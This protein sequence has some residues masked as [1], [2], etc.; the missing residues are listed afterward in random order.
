MSSLVTA[1]V[2]LVLLVRLAWERWL[3]ERNLAFGAVTPNPLVG[4][5]GG[6]PLTPELMA[7]AVAYQRART[8]FGHVAEVL[9][10]LGLA[11]LLFSGVLPAAWRW[12]TGQGLD[13]VAASA[14][15]AAGALLLMA[16]VRIPLDWHETFRLE[17][18]FGF[19][20]STPALFWRDSLKRLLLT[21]VLGV[22][23]FTALTVLAGY[24]GPWWWLMAA[25]MAVAFQ[26]L[27]TLLY[28]L[29]ILPWF[30]HCAPLE[31]DLLMSLKEMAHDCRFPTNGFWVLNSSRRSRHSN[32]FVAGVGQARRIVLQDTLLQLLEKAEI[33]A[34]VAHEIG[35]CRNGH[36]SKLA[37][38]V[39]L[40][41]TAGFF[42]ASRLL[43]Y[44]P[45]LEGFGFVAGETAP[46][47]LTLVL[48][49]G[50]LL[51]WLTPLLH[52]VQRHFEHDADRVAL[53]ATYS[54]QPLIS[55]LAKISANSLQILEPHPWY[56]LY[57]HSHPTLAQRLEALKRI[58]RHL[59]GR[60]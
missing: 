49:A 50:P 33:K 57:H 3:A 6:T 28:P 42:A 22:P 47:L 10:T 27:A 2:A 4:V 21:L 1:V 15:L 12:L 41:L 39:A 37:L 34:V 29:L 51:F 48:A 43:A 23:L 54:P 58:Q 53:G 14:T 35:H 52:A 17:A 5:Y 24:G 25:G 26:L 55:A 38:L 40:L 16:A 13:E 31:G 8:R 46:T 36:L 18:R 9:N 19:N 7:R 44:P 56:S 30:N 20:S 32:A 11:V 45:F 60:V 59:T